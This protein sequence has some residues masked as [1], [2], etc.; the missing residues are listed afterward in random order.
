MVLGGC[1]LLSSCADHF[2]Y[3]LKLLNGH[4][5]SLSSD[6]GALQN[7]GQKI[8]NKLGCVYSQGWMCLI[9]V[10][11]VDRS[12]WHIREE[13]EVNWWCD[14]LQHMSTTHAGA[15]Q[16]IQLSAAATTA[17]DWWLRWSRDDN[18]LRQP[19]V[20]CQVKQLFS[21]SYIWQAQRRFTIWPKSFLSALSFSFV[22]RSQTHYVSFLHLCSGTTSITAM[23]HQ[24][25]NKCSCWIKEHV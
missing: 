22:M 15:W 8:K 6:C 2:C 24:I 7:S 16:Q 20:L 14:D 1:C 3:S 19:I 25:M 12:Y 9:P 18:R 21:L 11:I 23:A 10:L 17:S 4:S 5:C 13:P